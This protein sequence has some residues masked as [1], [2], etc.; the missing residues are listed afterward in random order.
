MSADY[1]KAWIMGPD[2]EVRHPRNSFELTR[3]H[4]QDDRDLVTNEL[5]VRILQELEKANY[6]AA[7]TGVSQHTGVT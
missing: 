4:K 7:R 1:R 3:A 5:L 6:G 2:G